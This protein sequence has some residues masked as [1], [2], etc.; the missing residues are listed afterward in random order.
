MEHLVT[1]HSKTILYFLW[2]SKSIDE[3]SI[4]RLSLELWVRKRQFC[5]R[6]DVYF[7]VCALLHP[8][9]L[10]INFLECWMHFSDGSAKVVTLSHHAM[11]AMNGFLRKLLYLQMSLRISSIPVCFPS[12]WCL[13]TLEEFHFDLCYQFVVRCNEQSSKTS[14]WSCRMPVVE[15][16]LSFLQILTWDLVFLGNTKELQQ[17]YSSSILYLL[18][19]EHLHIFVT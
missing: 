12:S 17:Q 14:L 13:P 19:N 7:S 11:R 18:W 15:I 10:T 5:L 6:L 2:G 3:K 4:F 9:P 1:S 16:P 8:Y